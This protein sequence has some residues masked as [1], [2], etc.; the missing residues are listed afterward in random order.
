MSTWTTKSFDR[1]RDYIVVKH[2]LN[3]VNSKVGGIK[4]RD[5]YAVVE[6]GSKSYFALK[7]VKPAAIAK[8]YPL[9]HLKDLRFVTR[10]ADIKIIFGVDVYNR[11]ILQLKQFL[12]K[13]V[14]EDHKKSDKCQ[15]ILESGQH[16]KQ[17][18]FELSPSKFCKQHLLKDPR[19]KEFGIEIP[20]VLFG[21]QRKN[22]FKQR[23]LKTLKKLKEDNKF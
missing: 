7:R 22:E 10:T 19:L 16:C 9:I 8:E 5:G 17:L 2:S 13:K 15:C 21:K 20:L 14:I 23:V 12:D 18:Q 11:Y 6:K 1:D 4:Y 3:G